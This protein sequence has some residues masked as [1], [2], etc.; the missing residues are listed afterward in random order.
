[1]TAFADDLQ[2][3]ATLEAGRA[4]QKPKIEGL[5]D[6]PCWQHAS[7]VKS[8]WV[9][10][11]SARRDDL[12]MAM[13]MYDDSHLYIAYRMALDKAYDVSGDTRTRDGEVWWPDRPNL[14][15]FIRP[16]VESALYFPYYEFVLNPLNTQMDSRDGVPSWQ[17][18][19]ESATRIAPDNS[20]W[21]AQIAIP[22]NLF[23]FDPQHRPSENWRLNLSCVVCADGKSTILTWAPSFFDLH[24]PSNFGHL[25][26]IVDVPWERWQ[27]RLAVSAE[28]DEAGRFDVAAEVAAGAE[29]DCEIEIAM[30]S[31]M[32]VET[33]QNRS[34]RELQ[35][36]RCE[37]FSFTY[38]QEGEYAL[39]AL[40]TESGTKRVLAERQVVAYSAHAFEAARRERIQ[41]QNVPTPKDTIAFHRIV[42]DVAHNPGATYARD[43]VI[44]PPMPIAIRQHHPGG[45]TY[46]EGLTYTFLVHSMKRP[47]LIRMD[48][49]RLVLV[50]TAWVHQN[51]V[52]TPIILHCDDEG[53]T[54]SEPREISIHGTLVSLRGKKLMVCDDQVIVSDDAGESWS[55]PEPFGPARLP[56][57][58]ACYHHGTMAV[59]GERVASIHCYTCPPYG[60]TGWTAYS[61]LRLSND[62][63]RT[64]GDPIPL[65]P[66]WCTSEGSVTRAKDGALVA[67]FRTAQALGLPSYCDAWRR[68]TTARSMD[69]GQTWT[70]HQVHFDYGKVHSELLT[71]SNGDIVMTYAVRMGE[72]DGQMYH[73][74]E[75]V[76]SH[77]HGKTWD[78]DKRF[79]LFRWA[80][81]QSMH[82]PVSVPLSDGRILTMFLYTYD[83]SYGQGSIGL[84]N[85][86]L[87][88]AVFWRPG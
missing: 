60:P 18:V 62:L 23:G 43:R 10:D 32:G 49:G 82:S 79:I 6:E 7:P 11:G 41:K 29:T 55:E 37:L 46:Q 48:D 56:D 25:T 80:M 4:R 73:G 78:W 83:A 77:D 57:G 36:K 76:L 47:R 1:M 54:W 71:L 70:H 5:L 75:A 59:E 27:H 51:N 2:S 8:F 33:R 28:P 21:Q 12:A 68:I 58:K 45:P 67:S 19:W 50:A 87:V 17:G 61:V 26:G 84:Q 3:S 85:L 72:L 14:Q 64:W 24:V 35:A 9:Y 66:E 15:V 22:H 39:K 74:V 13:V 38:E 52:E 42:G 34:L 16:C 88:S 31:P 65:P 30:T 81:G 86:G 44:S 69:D 63:G 20:W 40:M 53:R